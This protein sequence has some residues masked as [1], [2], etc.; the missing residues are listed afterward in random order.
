MTIILVVEEEQVVEELV[1][2]TILDLTAL[3]QMEGLE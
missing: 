2:L 3:E 1:A